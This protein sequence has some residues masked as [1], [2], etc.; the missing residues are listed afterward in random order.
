MPNKSEV[1]LKTY[2]CLA[3]VPALVKARY[4]NEK[5]INTT[6]SERNLEQGRSIKFQTTYV[7]GDTKK[8]TS[9]PPIDTTNQSMHAVSPCKKFQAV[10][11]DVEQ[12]D[13][14]ESAQYL[15]IW[16]ETSLIR[17]VDLTALD[18]HAKVYTDDEFGSFKWS[19]VGG[20]ILYVA[21][22]R[23]P[24]IDPLHKRLK[25]K[26]DSD[27]TD[28]DDVEKDII[29]IETYRQDW[30]EALVDKISSIVVVYD[31]ETDEFTIPEGIPDNV[32]VA[33]PFWTADGTQIIGICL[34]TEPRKLGLIYCGNRPSGLFTLTLNNTYKEFGKLMN[35]T[36]K[37]PRLTPNGEHIIWLQCD[38]GGPHIN[39]MQLYKA[40]LPLTDETEPQLILDS[41]DVAKEISGGRLFYGLFSTSIP[42]RCW[43]NDGRL[44]FSTFRKNAITAY[45]LD[46]DSGKLSEFECEDG[47]QIVLDVFDDNV[48]INRRNFF[49]QDVLLKGVLPASGQENTMSLEQ[50]SV[51]NVPD[52]LKDK[53][54]EYMDLSHANNDEVDNFT[55]I[56]IGPKSAEDASIPLVI[57]PHGGPH[58]ASVNALTLENAFLLSIGYA[59]VFVNYRGSIGAGQKSL[60]FLP[61]KCGETDVADCVLATNTALKTFP[62]LNSKRISLV[63][64]SHGGFL[65]THLSGQYPDMWRAVVARNPVTDISTM[66][67]ASDI[68]D[69]C[70]VEAGFEYSQVGPIRDDILL[71]M[72]AKSPIVHAHKVKAPTLLQIGTKDLRV[73]P[74]Q[75]MDYFHR[76]K[77]N[78]ITASMNIYTDNHPLGLVPNEIGHILSTA[79]WL[80]EHN[81]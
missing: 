36:V 53:K 63:G 31:V 16:N 25:P 75:G 46:L 2:K 22:K 34:H 11:R 52:S 43:S 54:F 9:L 3:Q 70:Y 56:Y 14:K 23:V 32:C 10:L 38:A 51:T 30:G 24:K 13:Q 19:P 47:S 15:E 62:W 61:G 7:S 57:F 17:S 4:L 21:E 28:E 73:P 60:A 71:A 45:V 78:N 49:Q 26:K 50:V 72:R 42:E 6:W 66:S 48:L 37:G 69:W 74:F 65:V 68:P 1:L 80:N 20:K 44:L 33:K 59:V 18:L 58:S 81:E 40:K 55:A 64:G 12:K 29:E 76:L 8:W 41:V 39:C 77:A 79:T 67:G 5:I 35:K 27:T